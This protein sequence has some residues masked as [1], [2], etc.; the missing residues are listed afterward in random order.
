MVMRVE[1]FYIII[2]SYSIN[3]LYQDM[4]MVAKLQI[5]MLH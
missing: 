3:I 4:N 1:V 5:N 2:C